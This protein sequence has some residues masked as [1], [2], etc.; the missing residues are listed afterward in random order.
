[1]DIERIRSLDFLRGLA[2]IG[3]IAF[4]LDAY[5][6]PPGSFLN[7]LAAQGILGVQLFFL[8]SAITMCTMWERRAGEAD[9][10]L[11]FYIRRV[12]RIAGPFW[13]AMIFYLY[14]DGFA[15]SHW[16]P[17]G[18]STRHILTTALFVHALWPDTVNSVVPG[19]WSIGVEM[20]FYLFFPLVANLRGSARLYLSLGFGVYLLNLILVRPLYEFSLAGFGNEELVGEFLY[21]QLFNQGPV[22]LVGMAIYQVIKGQKLGLASWAIIAI[23]ITTSFLLKYGFHCSGSPYFWLPVFLLAACTYAAIKLGISLKP[24]E[25]FGEVSYSVYLSHFAVI[26]MAK[27]IFAKANV[28]MTNYAAF[29]LALTFVILISWA[30]GVA[31]RTF[32]EK[33]SSSVGRILVRGLPNSPLTNQP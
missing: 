33:P 15:A 10:T 4:H 12:S 13:M 28:S 3:V 19:G 30:I 20:L 31:M 5:F 14:L 1:M 23:W 27:W 2:I 22:F 24:L 29:V 9:P 7:F 6:G 17:N 18:I 11:K 32:I 8:I 16:A 26:S 25:L 21:F